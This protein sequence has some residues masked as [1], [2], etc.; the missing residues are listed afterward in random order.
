MTGAGKLHLLE[1]DDLLEIAQ[2]IAGDHILQSHRGG[3]VA[4]EHFLDLGALAGVHLQEAPDALFLAL[5]RHEHRVAG[6]QHPGIDAKEGQVADEGIVQDLERQSRER[7]RVARLAGRRLAV[8]VDALD[9]RHIDRRGHVLDDRIEQRLHAL[10]LEGRPHMREHDLVTD[11]ALAQTLTD[12]LVRE[13]VVLEVAVHQGVV[14]LGRRLDHLGAVF[15]RLGLE[16]RRDVAVGELHPLG[17]HVPVDRLHADEVDH[18][19]EIRLRR[20]WP[21]GS[22]PCWRAGGCGSSPPRAGNPHPRG[23]SC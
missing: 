11:R 17:L 19:L 22:A 7:R 12:V 6:V 15:L 4:G 5:A 2:R 13:C 3:D 16:A 14:G 9:V 21:A 20:R 10:V 23:P 1:R 18:A 8:V